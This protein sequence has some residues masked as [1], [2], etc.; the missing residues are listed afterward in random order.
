MLRNDPNQGAFARK[1]V[2]VAVE[3][4]A[5]GI[6]VGIPVRQDGSLT[7]PATDSPIVGIGLLPFSVTVA[8]LYAGH[9]GPDLVVVSRKTAVLCVEYSLHALPD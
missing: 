5:A 1:I 8:T 4:G 9:S 6:V 3:Q 2:D 7:D